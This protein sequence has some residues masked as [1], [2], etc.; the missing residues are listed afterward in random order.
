MTRRSE[1]GPR[2]SLTSRR[3]YPTARRPSKAADVRFNAPM[4]WDEQL[5]AAWVLL[6]AEAD[7]MLRTAVE[8][9]GATYHGSRRRSVRHR[10]GRSLVVRYSVEL[11]DAR[12]HRRES[13]TAVVDRNGPPDGTLVL[14]ADGLAVGLFRHPHDPYLPGLLAATT[15]GASDGPRPDLALVSYR[16]CDR[17]VVRARHADGRTEYLKVVEPEDFADVLARHL[18]AAPVPAPEVLRAD[19]DLAIVVLAELPGRPLR[20]AVLD[21]AEVPDPGRLLEMLGRLARAPLDL[22]VARLGPLA[23]APR[24]AALLRSILPASRRRIDRFVEA[25]GEVELDERRVIH[26]DLH[27]GQVFVDGGRL[28]GLVDLD[29]AGRGDPV[30]DLA[31]HLAHLSTLL[32]TRRSAA[33][34]AHLAATL[35]AFEAVT[36]P[37][38][39]HRR[40]AAHVF[41]L[42][43]GPHR[44]QR[45]GWEGASRRRLDLAERWLRGD[46]ASLKSRG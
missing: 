6:G 44:V 42:A 8:S 39:L 24:H 3:P 2:W 17:A 25:L 40:V 38:G 35:T 27:P 33:G 1:R 15:T 34:N 22:D 30:D 9:T 23:A 13:I 10:P 28:T 16:P 5:P 12:G 4:V 37:P 21:G 19:D 20:D 36:D 32:V 46:V 18:A 43:A 11:T 41:A 45:E 14:E 26:G 7:A 31:T 29:D